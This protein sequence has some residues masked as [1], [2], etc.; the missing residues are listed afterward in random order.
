MWVPHVSEEVLEG[1][2]AGRP[3]NLSPLPAVNGGELG[4]AAKREK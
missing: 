3:V 4:F 2:E 1:A